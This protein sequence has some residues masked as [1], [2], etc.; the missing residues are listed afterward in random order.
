MSNITNHATFVAYVQALAA[1]EAQA[2]KLFGDNVEAIKNAGKALFDCY[3]AN[4]KGS[5]A[6]AD[7][8]QTLGISAWEPARVSN[9]SLIHI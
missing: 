6:R 3:E 4:A 8:K 1:N 5:K 9:L 2:S 7:M